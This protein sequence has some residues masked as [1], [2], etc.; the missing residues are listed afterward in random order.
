MENQELQITW[1]FQGCRMRGLHRRGWRY[2]TVTYIF[3]KMVLG[4]L[5]LYVTDNAAGSMQGVTG[6][7]W[8]DVWC[9]SF[10]ALRN[11]EFNFIRTSTWCS[12]TQLNQLLELW[13]IFTVSVRI[14]QLDEE[15]HNHT[16]CFLNH[17]TGEQALDL[18][19]DVRFLSRE[20]LSHIVQIHGQQEWR[21]WGKK[22]SLNYG[23]LQGDG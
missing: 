3:Q 13:V 5:T 9:L 18:K 19:L 8:F 23:M 22:R 7:R 17:F 2:G 4:S 21:S 12:N 20:M 10:T 6:Q 11:V 16:R 1:S 14:N 15:N